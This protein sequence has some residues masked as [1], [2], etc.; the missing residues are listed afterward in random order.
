MKLFFTLCSF[1]LTRYYASLTDI[2]NSVA[3]FALI[4][5]ISAVSAGPTFTN[6]D[7]LVIG[8]IWTASVLS[9][10]LTLD[11]IFN[12]DFREG[13]ADLFILCSVSLEILSLAKAFSYWLTNCLSIITVASF[14]FLLMGFKFEF[15]LNFLVCISLVTLTMSLI[16][17]ALSALTANSR[18]GTLLLTILVFP[19]MIPPVIFGTSSSLN[20]YNGLDVSNEVL[21]LIGFFMLLLST[22]PWASA[23][24]IKTRIH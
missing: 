1:E 2:L 24:A 14:T 13:T 23:A 9:C 20:A 8:S 11:L 15:I 10:V 3:F 12:K 7:Y 19:M 6:N 22:L 5:I 16:G 21:F 4:I 18:N 17:V